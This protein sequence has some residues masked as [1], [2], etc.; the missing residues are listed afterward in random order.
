MSQY[1]GMNSNGQLEPLAVSPVRSKV[2]NDHPYDSPSVSP[3]GPRTLE[4]LKLDHYTSDYHVPI[5]NTEEMSR[6]SKNTYHSNMARTGMSYGKKLRSHTESAVS[7]SLS[8]RPG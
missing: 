5:R 3:R 6:T 8:V 1:D 4:P 7:K 2:F